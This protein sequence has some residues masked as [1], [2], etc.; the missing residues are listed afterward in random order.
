MFV[1]AFLLAAAQAASQQP[2]SLGGLD[3]P[4]RLAIEPGL[5]EPG[6]RVTF[7]SF[8]KHAANPV[9][10]PDREW[11]GSSA[12][13]YGT[14]LPAE[15]G[16]GLR[17]WYHAYVRAPEFF[18]SKHSYS[19]AYAESRDGIHWTKPF[20]DAIPFR[21][22]LANNMF[23]MRERGPGADHAP[24]VIHTPWDA[25]DRRY[26]LINYVYYDGYWGAVSADGKQWKDLPRNPVLEDP[27]DVG[28][29]VWDANRG[30]YIGYPKTF[31]Q[32]RGFRRRCVGF[33]ETRDFAQWPKS[34]PILAPD[35]EDDRWVTS[36]DGHTDFYGLS[37]F[38]YQNMYVGFLWI[39]RIDRMEQRIWPEL[40]YGKDGVHWTRHPTPRAPV[41]PLGSPGT[42]DDGMIFT[43]N[44]PLIRDDKL[45]LYYG[46]FD[47]P[48]DSRTANAAVGLA[49][50]RRDGFASFD[51]G[52]APAV[53]TTKTLANVSGPL[54]VNANASA[55]AIAAEVLD[56]N[57]AALP[58]YTLAE[59]EPVRVNS[60]RAEIRWKTRRDLPTGRP[61]KLRFRLESAELYSFLAGPVR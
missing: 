8:E 58:G 48:H 19:N 17:M 54:A 45:V 47:G 30:C 7:H 42:W 46:G 14:V 28:N 41:L 51:A 6:P 44:H 60:V 57:G 25:P 27:G 24:N 9:L 55:G 11:E 59:C 2:R 33:S 40:V 1:I 20:L 61:V 38:P 36:S 29:F 23:L 15:S 35:I 32:E 26:K 16:P 21:G 31:S 5:W 50:M 53:V 3:G 22:S 10:R 39:Y 12:Y 52:R 4:W 49:T 43:S 13:L 56:A 37:A 18:G 34:K